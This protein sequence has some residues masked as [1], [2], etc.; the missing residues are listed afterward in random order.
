MVSFGCCHSCEI[1]FGNCLSGKTAAQNDSEM[2]L[3]TGTKAH[4]ITHLLVV[5]LLAVL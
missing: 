2:Y 5:L 1:D 4:S 3:L